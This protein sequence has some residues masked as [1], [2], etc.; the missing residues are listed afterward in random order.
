M[1]GRA[2]GRLP[3]EWHGFRVRALARSILSQPHAVVVPGQ[4]QHHSN[5]PLK[6]VAG[7][8][9]PHRFIP[10]ADSIRSTA[11]NSDQVDSRE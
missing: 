9:Q 3:S 11:E 2:R 4:Y 8:P 1:H 5:R 7:G 6:L 10:R